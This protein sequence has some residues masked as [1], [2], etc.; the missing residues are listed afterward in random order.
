MLMT[1]E[2]V[3]QGEMLVGLK[4]VTSSPP[5]FN[6]QQALSKNEMDFDLHRMAAVWRSG[7]LKSVTGRWDAISSNKAT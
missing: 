6:R 1:R 7:E 3:A 4:L 2:P 5:T